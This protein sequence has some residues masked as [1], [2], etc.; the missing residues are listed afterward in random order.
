VVTMGTG[1]VTFLITDQVSSTEWLSRLGDDAAD[2]VRRSHFLLVRDAVRAKGGQDVKNLGDGLMAAF[3]S[4]MDAVDCAIAV[5]QALDRRN[6]QSDVPPIVV[7][8][9]LDIGE[10]SSEESDYFGSPV[11]IATR[12]CAAARGGQILVS[13][14]LRRLVERRGRFTFGPATALRLKGFPEPVMASEV[15]WTPS[16]GSPVPFPL[17]LTASDA[18]FIG[19]VSELQRLQ[20]WWERAQAGTPK[21]A[22]IAG[23]PGV[24]K[25]RLSQKFA[26]AVAAEGT[27]T[28]LFGRCDEE[29]LSPY[30]PFVEA[31]SSYL[32]ACPVD[33]LAMQVAGVE[34]ELALLVPGLAR[35]IPVEAGSLQAGT[36]DR[37]RLFEAVASLFRKAS[38]TAPLLLV[39][40]DLQWAE[41]PTALLLR[42]LVRHLGR[43]RVLVVGVY[44]DA[45]V[46]HRHPLV[47][48][49]ANLRRDH[50]VEDLPLTGLG[51]GEVAVLIN[52]LAGWESPPSLV[53]AVLKVSEGN[54]FFVESL[55]HHLAGSGTAVVAPGLRSPD[56]NLEQLGLPDDIREITGRRLA[57][58]SARCHRALAIASVAGQTFDLAVLGR[59]SSLEDDEL[60]DI[61]EEATAARVIFELPDAVDQY[62][63]GH[64]L[65]RQT[66]YQELSRSRR[67]RLHRRIGEAVEALHPDD[68]DRY[69]EALAYHFL[70]AEGVGE[71]GKAVS[72]ALQAAERS[73]TMLAYEESADLC[74]QALDVLD[75]RGPLGS[76]ERVEALLLLGR[77]LRSLGESQE[78]RDIFARAGRAAAT[79]GATK[80]L[81]RAALGYGEVPVEIGVVDAQLIGM[82]EDALGVL[83]GE[84]AMRVRLLARLAEELY[85]SDDRDRPP[86]LAREA[87]EMARRVGEPAGLVE[88]LRIQRLYKYGPDDVA[89][90]L[91]MS[92]EMVRIAEGAGDREGA[93]KSRITRFVDLVE[94]GDMREMDQEIEVIANLAEALR[95]PSYLWFPAKWRAMRALM[96]GRVEEGERLVQETFAVGEQRHGQTAVQAYLIQL[97]EVRRFQGRL[98]EVEPALEATV[99][100]Y[101][102]MPA[103]R[104]ALAWLWNELGR[105]EDARR[106]LL[107]LAADDFAGLPRDALWLTAVAI[108]AEVAASVG[109]ARLGSLL[110]ELLQ[111]YASQCVFVGT[112]DVFA[113]CVPAYLAHAATAAGDWEAAERQFGEAVRCYRAIGAEP[114]EAYSRCGEAQMLL[115]RDGPGDRERAGRQLGDSRLIAERLALD[116]LLDRINL[117]TS[118]MAPSKANR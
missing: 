115:A 112:A 107:A 56:M 92:S 110:Y 97:T 52:K 58:L 98:P 14:L 1:V 95:Q 105:K 57:H 21:L 27:A 48:A 100:Q 83:P 90:R 40:D 26:R 46:S 104:C 103:W 51:G 20:G 76:G 77:A 80:A 61:V 64:A 42:H 35:R 66:L 19:R 71:P 108:L 23:E 29:S 10:P 24:G 45:E 30:Q 5:Q 89:E 37:Y 44:R 84:D 25:T 106:E 9:G 68:K 113:G 62:G 78:A 17:A 50:M 60:L 3:S 39:L 109:E 6:R 116:G 79:L 101:R 11:V 94:S 74:R 18:N 67:A 2:L 70:Q 43:S 72:Y 86:R 38:E 55:V 49:V 32:L 13:D 7:R 91:A 4:P 82:L 93:L 85:Y 34:P 114:F 111:P 96:Q 8:I 102:A 12:L 73:L 69:L 16:I 53:Q 41:Q 81:G 117:L 75:R 33:Q 88:A 65:I 22:L 31:L 59:V 63:F 36:D 99:E 28:I 47:V 54:P 87:V 15:M 118:S